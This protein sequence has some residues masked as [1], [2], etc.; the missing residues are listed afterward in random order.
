MLN[1]L[2]TSSVLVVSCVLLSACQSFQHCSQ[3]ETQCFKP[4]KNALTQQAPKQFNAQYEYMRLTLN[5]RV[6]WLA[7]GANDAFATSV[8]YSADKNVF[9]WSHGRLVSVQQPPL[10][11]HEQILPQFNWSAIVQ[12]SSPVSFARTIDRV[13]GTISVKETRQ[14]QRAT[15]PAHHAFVGQAESLIWLHESTVN[16]NNKRDDFDSWYAFLPNALNEPVYGQQCIS[17][18]YCLTWQK[19]KATP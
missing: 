13:D 4:T 15:A 10:V 12:N 11:W 16:P 19:W 5:G 3:Q 2:Q 17:S 7:K 1:I 8:Y 6:A 14:V 18:T 9:K